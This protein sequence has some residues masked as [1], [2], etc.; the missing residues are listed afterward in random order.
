MKAERP[1][2]HEETV[3]LM[4]SGSSKNLKIGNV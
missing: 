4:R 3:A 2:S 1:P